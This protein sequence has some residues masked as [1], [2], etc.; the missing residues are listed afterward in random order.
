LLPM[1]I[2]STFSFLATSAIPSAGDPI[3]IINLTLTNY[4]P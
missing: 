3:P 1:I 2:K 4:V